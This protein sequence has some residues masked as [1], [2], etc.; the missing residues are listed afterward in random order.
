MAATKKVS[1]ER[2]LEA[3]RASGS[4]W[5]AGEAV[6]L[7]GQSVHERLVGLGA[8]KS[9]NRW[10]A[11]DDAI[12]IEK[13]QV[14]RDNGLLE[15]L[16]KSLGRTKHFVCRKAKRLGLTNPQARTW[17]EAK[18]K[19]LA[20]VNSTNSRRRIA[21][22]GHPRGMLGKKH[23]SETRKIIGESSI[24]SWHSRTDDQNAAIVM[25]GLKTRE[26]N[27]TLY[28]PRKGATWKAAWRTIG[29]QRKYFRSR[30]EANYARYLE[31][32]KQCGEIKEWKHEPETFWFEAIKRGCR[33]YLPDFRVVKDD[34]SVEYHEV[35]GYM[36][37]K[38]KTKIKRMAK[39]HPKVT[40]ILVDAKAYRSLEK[41]CKALIRDW[42]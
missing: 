27:G 26:R 39:Y 18:R 25:R 9:V 15:E 3:Y 7:C 1:D 33:S 22:K 31:L 16:A 23:S 5:S 36:D 13:Y 34:D 30:W 10:T 28:M 4:V 11:N 24:V 41:S 6:G 37:S 19:Q 20:G 42:E 17:S 8:I 35:K 29:G 40:L 2:I 12:L 32:L 14:K 38:S 21:T